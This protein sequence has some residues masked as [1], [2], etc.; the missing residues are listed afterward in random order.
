MSPSALRW[1]RRGAI[2]VA[3]LM[4]AGFAVGSLAGRRSGDERSSAQTTA[5]DPGFRS[6]VGGGEPGA[7]VPAPDE[8]T[9][10]VAGS[11]VTG[12]GGA[13]SAARGPL[14]SLQVPPATDRVIKTAD[15]G[16]E[17]AEGRI[18][19]SW[20]RVFEIAS[21]L[22]GFVVSSNQGGPTP[23][24]DG[25]ADPRVGN[26]VIRVPANRFDQALTALSASEVG[27]VTR[28]GTSGQDVTQE[29]VDLESRL[30]HYRAQESVLLRIMSRARTIGDT[31]SVQQQLSQVQLQ[32]EEITG[33]LRYLKDQTA[34]ATISVHLAE[35]GAATGGASDGPSF[36]KAWDT[37]VEGL[38]RIG[39]AALIGATWLS[40][41][42]LLALAWLATRRWRTRPAPQA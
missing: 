39:T 26:I 12:G 18:D 41:F 6:S 25:D 35:T 28:R 30:R 1:L 10:P 24:D 8:A 11:A 23:I 17:V 5:N 2:A 29:F 3:V 33:R 22:G 19:R 16:I 14:G 9:G 36:S 27:K 21:S 32:I 13:G 15:V 31:I 4:V 34:F 7:P 40:P 20:N 38:E 42:A 37:A